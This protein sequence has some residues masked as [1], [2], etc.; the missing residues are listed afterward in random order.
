MNNRKGEIARMILM[1]LAVVGVVTVAVVAPNLLAAFG[2]YNKIV[3][4]RK[5]WV[6]KRSLANLQKTGDIK[7][8]QKGSETLIELTKNGRKRL[9][10][11]QL[12]EIIIKPQQKWDGKWRLVMYDIPSSLKKNSQYFSRKLKSLGFTQLQKS[13]LIYPYPCE[14][15]VRLL[16]NVYGIDKF[17]RI[18]TAESL[19]IPKESKIKP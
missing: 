1:T 15:E 4:N 16:E 13:V 10:R 18:A 8:R 12:E 7:V 6:V 3:K 5:N 11:F 19:D 14:E 17:V 2:R 9:L